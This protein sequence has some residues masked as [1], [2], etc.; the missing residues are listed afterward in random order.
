MLSIYQ[1]RHKLTDYKITKLNF[2]SIKNIFGGRNIVYLE[3][4][5]IQKLE[6][7]VTIIKIK[8]SMDGLT[9]SS[10]EEY[11]QTEMWRNQTWKIKKVYDM[12]IR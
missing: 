6:L 12:G 8:N 3:W 1:I 2:F 11:I 10:K 5:E 9:H 7:R 4:N